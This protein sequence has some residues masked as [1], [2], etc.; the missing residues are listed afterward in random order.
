M[1][2]WRNFTFVLIDHDILQCSFTIL[3]RWEF[4]WGLSSHSRILH[5]FG[6]LIIT[7]EG[8]QLLIYA[9]Q[10]WSLSNEGSLTCHTY[11]ATGQP[12]IMVIYEDPCHSH[13]LPSVWQWRPHY[14]SCPDRWSKSDL[15]L[16][17][18]TVYHYAT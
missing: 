12:F 4:V 1:H 9:R 3:T 14:L 15:P 7:G 10:S 5:L 6:D 11:Y 13:L 17:R 8:L 16:A 18:R 2:R